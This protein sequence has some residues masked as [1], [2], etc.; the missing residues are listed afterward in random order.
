M[1]SMDGW[2]DGW[3]DGSRDAFLCGYENIIAGSGNLKTQNLRTSGSGISPN[4]HQRT[5]GFHERAGSFLGSYSTC[6]KQH[7]YP[8]PYTHRLLPIIVIYQNRIF[9]FLIIVIINMMPREGLVS[10]LIPTPLWL[11]PLPSSP[12]SLNSIGLVTKWNWPSYQLGTL[13]SIYS[14]VVG[15]ES[16]LLL[17][18]LK[19]EIATV[20][21]GWGV[22][23]YL[24]LDCMTG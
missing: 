13:H 16:P 20:A 10:F 19:K 8:W 1:S 7:D 18:L 22:T 12:P 9:V 2:W 17:P 23:E 11:P 14:T 5:F 21:G 6:S 24:R 3:M 15:L 4:P